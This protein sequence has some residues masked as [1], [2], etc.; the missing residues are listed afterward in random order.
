MKL[1][2]VRLLFVFTFA[3]ALQAQVGHPDVG[4]RFTGRLSKISV[5][6]SSYC[7]VTDYQSSTVDITPDAPILIASRTC[8]G[9]SVSV[10]FLSHGFPATIPVSTLSDTPGGLHLAFSEPIT[11]T[12][13]ARLRL[14][15]SNLPPKNTG[16]K[17]EMTTSTADLPGS[18]LGGGCRN[19]GS[20]IGPFSGLV[21][22]TLTQQGCARAIRWIDY[23]APAGTAAPSTLRI[24]TT[25]G[26][27]VEP[28]S[29]A[30]IVAV[31]LTAT[32]IMEEVI[33]ADVEPGRFLAVQ[34]VQDLTGAP[35]EMVRGKSTLVRVFPRVAGG[36]PKLV[37]GVR[38]LLSAREF[39]GLFLPAMNTAAAYA[40]S[41]GDVDQEGDSL[42][43]LLPREWTLVPKLTLTVELGLDGEANKENNSNKDPFVV[44]FTESAREPVDI[45][46]MGVCFVLDLVKV[47]PGVVPDRLPGLLSAVLPVD[48]ANVRMTNIPNIMTYPDGLEIS[49]RPGQFLKRMAVIA[50]ILRLS[51]NREGKT[52]G[53]TLFFP[54]IPEPP[55]PPREPG[56]DTR[57]LFGL[58][59]FI[60]LCESTR[61]VVGRDC[62]E[63]SS[64]NAVGRVLLNLGGSPEGQKGNELGFDSSNLTIVRTSAP[65][66]IT[67]QGGWITRIDYEAV[68]KALLA[69]EAVPSA[70]TA[71]DAAPRREPRA[72]DGLTDTLI[73][74]G[75]LRKDGTSARLDPAIRIP[76]SIA[77]T[78][79]ADGPWCVRAERGL[80][81]PHEVCFHATVTGDPNEDIFAV[82]IAWFDD[83]T[84]VV[85]YQRGSPGTELASLNAGQPISLRFTS[86]QA[87]EVWEGKRTLSWTASEPSGRS[88][89]FALV[90]SNNGGATWQPLATDLERTQFEA[91]TS[92]MVG[93]SVQFRVIASSGLTSAIA[94]VGPVTVQQAPVMSVPIR[95]VD[96][97]NLA[98]GEVGRE[99]IVVRN[100]GTGPLIVSAT[101]AAGAA[102]RI[103]GATT[104]TVP[105]GQEGVLVVRY[106]P[107]SAGQDQTELRLE[108]AGA[109][110][111]VTLRG[112]S[113][114][115]PVAS[116]RVESIVDFGKLAVGSSTDAAIAVRNTG[117]AA[118]SIQS[119]SGSS[120]VFQPVSTSLIVPAGGQAELLVRVRPAADG[121][122]SGTLTLRSNDPTNPAMA[123]TV[124]ATGTVPDTASIEVSPL[125]LDF[126]SVAAGSFR[127]LDLTIRNRGRAPLTITGFSSSN[128]RFA[129]T[130]PA[131]PATIQPGGQTVAVV[132]F[133]PP[134][135]GAETG[136]LT[137]TSNAPES[138][139]A[140]GLRGTGTGSATLQV[141]PASL[142]FG[143]VTVNQSREAPLTLR[144]TGTAALTIT[145][146]ISTNARFTVV[147][148]VA[149]L[150]I[151][152]GGSQP[153]TVRF[154]PVAPGQATATL[155]IASN[156]PEATVPLSGTGVSAAAGAIEISPASL[157]F[158]SVNTGQSRDFALTIRNTGNAALALTSVTLS[159]PLFGLGQAFAG[160]SVPAG[161]ALTL[162]VR[163]T[164]VSAGTHTG[165]LTVLSNDAA[166]PSITVA[167]TGT[168]APAGGGTCPST[169]NVA[170]NKPASQ[171][172]GTTPAS[173]GNNGII[174]EPNAYGFHTNV[175]QSPW[176]QVD[177]GTLSTICEVR[178]YNRADESF[179]R[180]RTVQVRFSNDG[181]NFTTAYAH[182]GTVWGVGGTP[183]L[184][185]MN[186][187]RGRTA[188]YVRIQLAEIEYLHLREVEVYGFS[189]VGGGGT[190][191]GPAISVSPTTIDFGTVALGSTAT[192][193]LTITNTGTAALNSSLGVASPFALS[194]ADIPLLA[195]GASA[196]STIRFTPTSAG[197]ATQNLTIAT[198]DPARPLVTVV[199]TGMGSGAVSQ[200]AIL[201]VDDGEFEQL[202]GFP[203]GGV[204]GYFVNRL[205]PARYPA[206]LRAVQIF[207]PE[208]ERSVGA[209]V[210]ILA[211]GNPGGAGPSQLSGISFQATAGT[212]NTL[213]Q[214]VEYA[215]TP[216]T[217]QSGDFLVGF[218]AV[219]GVNVFPA[220][221]D[222]TPPSRG[223]SYISPDG[224]TFRTLEAANGIGNL[225]I[226]ARVD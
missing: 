198:N 196:N 28:V 223:R 177:L 34:A 218:S 104:L 190:T 48:D 25:A 150:S 57:V 69:R 202:A 81:T 67:Q 106:V 129:V 103:E 90:Y 65:P 151:A 10:Q 2:L 128:G 27:A 135:A 59:T 138:A 43:F 84:R 107:V 175:E 180:A 179:A 187:V 178:L 139:P 191:S 145:S 167:L 11:T 119:V 220:V 197:P 55:A 14:S 60:S 102:F 195:P 170:L 121:I 31:G 111:T 173:L 199:V 1:L 117:R 62:A 215:V 21:E 23:V 126:G 47:C 161:S 116:L 29:G 185:I 71:D 74:S 143:S 54:W 38:G 44:E 206:T 171:S 200:P 97:R 194:P 82:Q 33:V 17:L 226:R 46:T 213:E 92:L 3:S 109:V 39:P 6:T 88:L 225:G 20:T 125:T 148:A 208:G 4:R 201:S 122:V 152:A 91:D 214:F 83:I 219:N 127:T 149:P 113:F 30:P 124:T 37:F 188:R 94:D 186:E 15:D 166:R 155:S 159:N 114:D 169:T 86:P 58:N 12:A 75:Y 147:G 165:T 68:R 133:S 156:G 120:A 101:L 89:S 224:V 217:I 77:D 136:T 79:A 162:I 164:P 66:N 181:V 64:R 142:D 50:K 108:G 221:I 153:V 158:G 7:A 45:Y 205:T 19:L 184:V 95:N 137:V 112:A 222:T 5:F 192:R 140:V 211:A 176:W 18:V 61:T 115:T 22:Q 41:G 210:N 52:N 78:T 118:L 49:E 35:V 36:D 80:G 212:I 172:S 163:F 51:L 56:L 130:A 209:A 100:T 73:L 13:S 16:G 131:V 8:N 87:G 110:E 63:L 189:G 193:T 72:A 53:A 9:Y 183:A 174:N 141:T 123:I 132:R 70:G 76:E 154:T 42:N 204:T 99:R 96:F 203:A 40:G 134:V 26:A 32:Y 146:L 105:A 85:L 168:G 98:P 182:N 160:S 24:R 93:G 216:V 157:D 144:N 207:F